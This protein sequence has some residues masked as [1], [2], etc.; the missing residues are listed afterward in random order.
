VAT[1]VIE[2]KEINKERLYIVPDNIHF[3]T[4]LE[5]GD[6]FTWN[7]VFEDQD[8][9]SEY[10]VWIVPNVFKTMA[11]VAKIHLYDDLETVSSIIRSD[12][13]IYLYKR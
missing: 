11:D 6:Y 10:I 5:V 4:A 12:Y 1:G 3:A 2:F 13:S 7:G 8:T 9:S